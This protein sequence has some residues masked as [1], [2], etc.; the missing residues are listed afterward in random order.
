MQGLISS[1]SPGKPVILRYLIKPLSLQLREAKLILRGNR[2][3]FQRHITLDK[4]DFGAIEY[5]LRKGRRQL[6]MYSSPGIKDIK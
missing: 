3:E 5:L 6:E 1:P 2:T 4:K